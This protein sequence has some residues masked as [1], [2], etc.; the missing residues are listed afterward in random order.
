AQ[1]RLEAHPRARASGAR[2]PPPRGKGAPALARRT[3][4][5]RCGGV[6]R[7]AA[8]RM[9]IA[10][11][12]ARAVTAA[13]RSPSR[14]AEAERNDDMSTRQDVT[15]RVTHRYNASPERV[16]DAW[17]DPTLIDGWMFGPSQRDEEVVRISV[18]PRVG[19]SFSF[20]VRRQ[21]EEIDHV[22][23]YIELDRP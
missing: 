6:D 15:V 4:P 20:L 14:Q 10:P 11:R 21:G 7:I 5:R 3:P 8:G 19:G 12:R 13:T 1:R 9:D 18:D 23:E 17:L 16:F 22:G 2:A